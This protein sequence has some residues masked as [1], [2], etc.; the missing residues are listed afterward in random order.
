MLQERDGDR[1]DLDLDTKT[2]HYTTARSFAEQLSDTDVERN[3]QLL[4]QMAKLYRLAEDTELAERAEIFMQGQDAMRDLY[5]D[6]EVSAVTQ[7][8]VV[9]MCS[10]RC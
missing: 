8:K 1:D 5:A 9:A 2:F 3:V 7:D 6:E 4:S 10:S